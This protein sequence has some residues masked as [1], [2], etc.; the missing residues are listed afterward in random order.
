MKKEKRTVRVCFDKIGVWF[1]LASHVLL[2]VPEQLG[3]FDFLV[4]CTC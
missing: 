2:Y 4:H 3:D 1:E